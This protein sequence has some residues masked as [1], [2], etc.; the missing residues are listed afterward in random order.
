MN[1]RV[2][3]HLGESNLIL[4]KHTFPLIQEHFIG[5]PDVVQYNYLGS[6]GQVRSI[7]MH[8]YQLCDQGFYDNI[9]ELDSQIRLKYAN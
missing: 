1:I 7:V 2:R 8:E 3:V 6:N 5:R 9:A 4:H